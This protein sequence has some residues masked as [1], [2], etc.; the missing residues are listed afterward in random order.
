VHGL[1]I[2][3]RTA[4][5]LLTYLTHRDGDARLIHELARLLAPGAIAMAALHVL[6]VRF[7]S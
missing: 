3:F 6:A 4:A 7:P 1:L 5:V 2:T